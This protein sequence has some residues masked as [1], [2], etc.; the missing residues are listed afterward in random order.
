MQIK[1]K[2]RHLYTSIRMAKVKKKKKKKQPGNSK[3]WFKKMQNNNNSYIFLVGMQTFLSSHA[4]DWKQPKCSSSREWIKKVWSSRMMEY[5]S[6]VKWNEPFTYETLW[7][8]PKAV[9]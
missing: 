7:M 9:G 6:A 1:T 4:K 2:T 3:Q 8:I 5:Y